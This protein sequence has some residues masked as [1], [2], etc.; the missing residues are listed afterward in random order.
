MFIHSYIFECTNKSGNVRPNFILVCQKSDQN[1]APILSTEY[2][3]LLLAPMVHVITIV[4]FGF[5]C[6]GSYSEPFHC[7]EEVLP[8]PFSGS[9]QELQVHK[10]LLKWGTASRKYIEMW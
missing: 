10:L 5:S 6:R 3:S 7:R 2:G 8:K 9:C 4:K 1:Y